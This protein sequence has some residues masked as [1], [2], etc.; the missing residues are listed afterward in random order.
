MTNWLKLL[1]SETLNRVSLKMWGVSYDELKSG[2]EKKDAEAIPA[3]QAK[4]N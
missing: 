2:G 1:W 4:G 3:S